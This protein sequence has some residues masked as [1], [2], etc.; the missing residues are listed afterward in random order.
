MSI[1]SYKQLLLPQE[2]HA[3]TNLLAVK[4]NQ[5]KESIIRSLLIIIYEKHFREKCIICPVFTASC[6]N[7]HLTLC[8]KK[9]ETKHWCSHC[10]ISQWKYLKAL[11]FSAL[12]W[13]FTFF[14][15]PTIPYLDALVTLEMRTA[16]KD[17][18]I[19]LF[20]PSK[21]LNHFIQVQY[22]CSGFLFSY[23]P[24]LACTNLANK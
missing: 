2:R 18:S 20:S 16:R 13:V 12:S 24:C 3:L 4:R 5:G 8:Y 10:D 15:F 17:F 11:N 9:K 6:L 22:A 14:G 1:S 21:N 19:K 23:F 7:A